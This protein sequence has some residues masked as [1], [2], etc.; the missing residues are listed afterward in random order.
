MIREKSPLLEASEALRDYRLAAAEKEQRKIQEAA[1]AK[2]EL[3]DSIANAKE[4]R[5]ANQRALREHTLN[6]KSQLLSDAFKSIYIGALMENTA[7]TD[8]GLDLAN[9][10]IEN[11]IKERGGA[12]VVLGKLDKTYVQEC[13]KNSVIGTCNAILEAEKEESDEDE[14]KDEKIDD[15]SEG[16]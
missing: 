2:K 3:E 11:Y 1:K 7:L 5:D 10:L 12:V 4:R 8:D 16:E 9:A 15:G 14:N 13:I 6:L